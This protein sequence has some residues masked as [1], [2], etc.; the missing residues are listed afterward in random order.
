MVP[1][2]QLSI[3]LYCDNNGSIVE[4][5]D[6]RNHKSGKHIEQKYY[7]IKEIVRRE[8]VIVIKVVSTDNLEDPFTKA[9]TSNVFQIHVDRMGVRCDIL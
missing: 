5:K 4:S 7:L 9:L 6:L 8:D 3:I 1:H 2:A